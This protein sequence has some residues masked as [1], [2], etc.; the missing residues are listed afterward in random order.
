MNE[1]QIYR[2]KLS[3]NDDLYIIDII[4]AYFNYLCSHNNNNNNSN[5]N[6]KFYIYVDDRCTIEAVYME[7]IKLLE[8]FGII[9]TKIIKYSSYDNILWIYLNRLIQLKEAY[10]SNNSVSGTMEDDDIR[11]IKYTSEVKVMFHDTV[12]F[13]N[14]VFNDMFYDIIIDDSERVTN[15]VLPTMSNL[16]SILVNTLKDTLKLNKPYKSS[17]DVILKIESYVSSNYVT[18]KLNMMDISPRILYDLNIKVTDMIDIINNNFDI[19]D[20]IIKFG[21]FEDV[22]SE[23]DNN[24]CVYLTNPV[25]VK[26]SETKCSTLWDG[27]GCTIDDFIYVEKEAVNKLIGHSKVRLKYAGLIKIDKIDNNY[28]GSWEESKNKSKSKIKHKHIL[29]WVPKTGIVLKEL[30]IVIYSKYIINSCTKIQ[31]IKIYNTYYVLNHETNSIEKL[32]LK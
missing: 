9:P 12:L 4:L 17:S 28:I 8:R 2:Y 5:S 10:I 25:I 30:N 27:V 26:I 23:L 22:E 20:Y 13:D 16:E 18:R 19:S 29:Y 3:I 21:K 6:N 31:L 24:T 15:I 1:I 14:N 11:K 32:N 7:K